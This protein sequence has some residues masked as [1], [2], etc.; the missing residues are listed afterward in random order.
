MFLAST[1]RL[2][3]TRAP[4]PCRQPPRARPSAH[5][6]ASAKGGDPA[7]HFE[8]TPARGEC[9]LEDA[10]DA[11]EACAKKVREGE[12]GGGGAGA[13]NDQKQR[14]GTGREHATIKNN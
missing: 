3:I 9:L 10:R 2:A 14:G 7:P 6:S 1:P 12:R 8:T 11:M 5:V 4:A 13:R